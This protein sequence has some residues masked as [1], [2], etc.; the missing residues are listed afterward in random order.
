MQVEEKTNRRHDRLSDYP[1][2]VLKVVHSLDYEFAISSIVL[3]ISST[4][5]SIAFSR[6]LAKPTGIS[7]EAIRSTGAS[8]HEKH[9]F[10]TYDAIS[11]PRP[12]VR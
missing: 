4:L 12:P 10:V 8:N 11:P 6:I 2:T 7:F 9:S 5:S 1:H 3:V